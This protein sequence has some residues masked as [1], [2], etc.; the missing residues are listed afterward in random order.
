[1]ESNFRG[2]L[3]TVP[4]CHL[5][6]CDENH[7]GMESL[8]IPAAWRAVL[9]GAASLACA[10][11]P[12]LNW[13][14]L[15][16]GE[17]AKASFP[18]RPQS[19]TR[20]LTLSGRP[21]QMQLKACEA[22]QVLWAVTSAQVADAGQAPE[23]LAE[24]RRSLVTNMVGSESLVP[25]TARVHIVGRRPDGSAIW[26]RAAFLSSGREVYQLVMLPHPGARAPTD[27]AQNYF[28]DGLRFESMK[29]AP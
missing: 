24:L 26:A 1:V 21:V 10:C 20:A 2:A 16:V 17:G 27:E 6:G 3:A 15:A 8:H 13:R 28:F 19:D 5:A 14:E 7:A 11:T 22:D 29:R 23:A 4:A 9:V 12:A 18:C 25:G